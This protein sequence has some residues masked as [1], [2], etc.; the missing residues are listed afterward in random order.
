MSE[1]QN[2]PEVTESQLQDIRETLVSQ[3]IQGAATAPAE[4]VLARMNRE[5][6]GGVAGYLADNY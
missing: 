3:G 1:T 2:T 5:W 6:N 4:K